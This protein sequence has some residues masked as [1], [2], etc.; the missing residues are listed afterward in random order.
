[1]LPEMHCTVFSGSNRLHFVGAPIKTQRQRQQQQQPSPL[2]HLLVPCPLSGP[3]L[4][5]PPWKRRGG[6][7]ASPRWYSTVRL[8][9]LIPTCTGQLS[10]TIRTKRKS[11]DDNY[12][13]VVD[14]HHQP[15]K[16]NP[17][18]EHWQ[19]AIRFV[20]WMFPGYPS[21]LDN[22]L[23]STTVLVV[24]PFIHL[25]GDGWSRLCCLSFRPWKVQC[26]AIRSS[27]NQSRPS[28]RCCRSPTGSTGPVTPLLESSTLSNQWSAWRS[29]ERE[30][31]WIRCRCLVEFSTAST[32]H[33]YLS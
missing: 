21:R 28:A 30:S 27:S 25:G 6:R 13:S 26:K 22:S 4:L 31:V 10:T 7:C 17:L 3:H 24:P 11:V 8:L 15:K 2:D 33:K 19:F 29:E 9:C 20:A 12:I 5:L 23:S 16:G 18:T 1:M 32:K 14:A